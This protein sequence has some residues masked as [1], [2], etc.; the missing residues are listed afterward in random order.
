MVKNKTVKAKLVFGDTWL[1]DKII[2]RNR[3]MLPEK[4]ECMG[5]EGRGIYLEEAKE[6]SGR[7]AIFYTLLW[8]VVTQM[9][10]L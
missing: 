7:L 2:M 8:V 1:G 10:A 4:G 5:E 6:T 9:L 3:K